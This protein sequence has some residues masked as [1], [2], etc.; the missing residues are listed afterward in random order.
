M[1]GSWVRRLEETLRVE[2]GSTTRETFVAMATAALVALMQEQDG[3]RRCGRDRSA[4]EFL[5]NED[6]AWE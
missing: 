3:A 6:V 5:G 1:R 2:G 4:E